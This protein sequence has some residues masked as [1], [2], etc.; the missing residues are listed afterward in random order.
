MCDGTNMIVTGVF[1]T[2]ES[3][4]YMGSASLSGKKIIRGQN[5]CIVT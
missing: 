5:G 1:G 2:T 3:H 4:Q